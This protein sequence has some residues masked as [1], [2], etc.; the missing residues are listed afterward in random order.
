MRK[1]FFN[2]YIFYIFL[3]TFRLCL[4]PK[5]FKRKYKGKKIEMK[6]RNKEKVK[7]DK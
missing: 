4:V 2:I 3:E 6:R 5:E 7:K 1:W